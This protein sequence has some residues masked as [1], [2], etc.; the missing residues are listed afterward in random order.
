MLNIEVTRSA[1]GV[2]QTKLFHGQAEIENWRQQM[3]PERWGSITPEVAKRGP[4]LEL[5]IDPRELAVEAYFAKRS[6][7]RD[8]ILT[9]EI[10]KRACGKLSCDEVEHTANALA[11]ETRARERFQGTPG[12]R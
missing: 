1:E 12:W 3:G 9:A 7:A 11:R 8:R 10:L 5:P 6:V 2:E 4:Q